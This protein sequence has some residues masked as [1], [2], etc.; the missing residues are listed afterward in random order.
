MY[1]LYAWICIHYIS[2]ISAYIS[3]ILFTHDIILYNLSISEPISRSHHQFLSRSPT[4][5]RRNLEPTNHIVLYSNLQWLGRN[6]WALECDHT[7]PPPASWIRDTFSSTETRCWLNCIGMQTRL[8]QP[9][10]HL[11][12]IKDKGDALALA[13]R[14]TYIRL[15]RLLSHCHS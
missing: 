15:C 3:Y 14:V 9:W 8:G 5:I 2:I 13:R 4:T 12:S 1:S 7:Q 11:F 10:P 6:R